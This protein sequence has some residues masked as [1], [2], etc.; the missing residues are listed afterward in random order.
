MSVGP[1]G[2]WGVNCNNDI[3]YREG[4][5]GDER[6]VGSRWRLVSGKLKQLTVGYNVVWGVNARDE[7]WI[8]VGKLPCVYILLFEYL[9]IK[10]IH[11]AKIF[12][13]ETHACIYACPKIY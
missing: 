1:A 2:V 7:I 9:C 3:W 5:Y 6:A 11:H 12:N 8:R 13:C 4:T 10:S